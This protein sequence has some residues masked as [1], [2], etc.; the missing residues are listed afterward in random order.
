LKKRTKKLLLLGVW[1]LAGRA[2]AGE[3]LVTT[4]AV[5][6][7]SLPEIVTAYGAA[8]PA[9]NGGMAISLQ[10]DGRVGAILVTQG[11][12]VS[13]GTRLLSFVTSAA[14][15]SAFAQATTALALAHTTRSHTAL[16][17]AQHLATRDQLAQADKGVAD[18]QAG[19]AALTEQ[20][21]NLPRAGVAAPFDAMV[22]TIQVAQGDRVAAGTTLM[23]LTRLDGLVVTVGVDPGLFA[24]VKAGQEAVLHALSGSLTLP[25]R[26][27]R[28]DG[29]INPKTRLLDVDISVPPGQVISG[30]LFRA[31]ISLAQ[32]SGWLVPHDSVLED[33]DG[34]F[35]FQLAGS[36]A[37]RVAVSVLG[38][39]GNQDLVTGPLQAT[40]P[41]VVDGATQ[42][43]DGD[44][45][46]IAAGASP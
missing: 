29:V 23:T 24:R 7:G 16:L 45:V 10:R 42:L 1:L 22:E 14:T 5:R 17:L 26:V 2:W 3:A 33:S 4:E 6:A 20:G 8:G 32:L 21:A 15:T 44:G 18:A 13:A 35:L 31:E 28:I 40:R 34:F 30:A 37:A 46:R 43:A 25:G 19:I 11:E 41:V 9:R 39:Q 38:T 12:R 36:H 27:L